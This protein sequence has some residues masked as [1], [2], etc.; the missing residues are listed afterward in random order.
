MSMCGGQACTSS[1]E[2]D[3]LRFLKFWMGVGPIILRYKW[4]MLLAGNDAENK[5]QRL[6]RLHKETAPEARKIAETFGGIFVKAGQG[7]SARPEIA[8][9]AFVKELRKLQSEVPASSWDSVRQSLE[10]ELGGKVGQIFDSFKQDPL[11]CASIGQ[12]HLATWRGKS[13]VVKVQYPGVA[14]KMRSDLANI[15]MLCKLVKPDVLPLISS[16][17]E[18]FEQELNYT[19]EYQA[20]AA[21][22][23]GINASPEFASRVAVPAPVPEISRGKVIGMEFLPGPKLETA[24]QERLEALGISLGG[25]SLKDF[26]MK[27]LQQGQDTS[28][29]A[30]DTSQDCAKS[31]IISGNSLELVS[32]NRGG[33]IA[34]CG[35]GI[36]QLCGF[37]RSMQMARKASDVR[38][39]LKRR[40]AGLNALQNLGELLRVVVRVHGYQMF[41][42]ALFNADPHPGNILL[43]PDG[44][45]GLIDFGFCV[46]LDLAE[47][48]LLAKLFIL[49]ADSPSYGVSAETDQQLMETV[50]SCGVRTENN[51]KEVLAQFPRFAFAKFESKW[52]E[53]GYIQGIITKDKVTDYPM[54][55]LLAGRCAAL[56]RGLCFGLQENISPAQEWAPYAKQWLQEHA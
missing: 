26:M 30:N 21:I 39:W 33:C 46:K 53:K 45:I 51:S 24:L 41:F 44:R 36:V 12:A 18:Q 55:L 56:L 19:L 11:G 37:D 38:L 13:I 52:L 6:E 43:L 50:L 27:Q 8:P 4:E 10:Q 22:H 28:S 31:S 7:I 23:E 17:C 40:N 16:M 15:T 5:E 47:K 29:D 1:N 32:S 25:A 2:I 49:L 35:R 48:R 14:A 20:L 54:F 3:D 9:D 42:C 34:S